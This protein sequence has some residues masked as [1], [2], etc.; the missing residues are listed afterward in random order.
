M[1]RGGAPHYRSRVMKEK[2]K[3]LE[4]IRRAADRPMTVRGLA[5][6]LGIKRADFPGFKRRIDELVEAGALVRVRRTRVA[7]PARPGRDRHE[8]LSL[9]RGRIAVTRGGAGFVGR[10]EGE[11]VRVSPA[12]LGGA[13][14]GD[15][16]AVRLAGR[17]AG[18]PAGV[19]VRVLERGRLRIV[20][21][22]ESG[23]GI[24]R[25]LPDDPRLPRAFEILPGGTG[26]AREGEK[27]VVL[28]EGGETPSAAPRGRVAEVLGDP[29]AP[30]VDLLSV[31]RS[32]GLTAEFPSR[33][34]EEAERAAVKE[35]AEEEARR[36][37]RTGDLVYTIDPV[38]A[39][40]HD[41]AISVERRADG[42]R[43]GV[44]IA[45]VSFYVEEGTALD[46]EAFRRGNSVYLPGLVIPMLPESLSND[47]CSLRPNRRR[48]AHSVFID[49]DKNGLALKWR[50]EDTVIRSR[51][52]LAYEE[53]QGFFDKGAA[54]ARIRRVAKGLEVARELALLLYRRRSEE[55]SLDFDLPEA[56]IVLDERGEVV[57]LGR[58]VRLE[59][60]RLI[61]E[62]M[63]AANRAV[64]R[65]VMGKGQ[66]FLYRVHGRPDKESLEFFSYMMN[67]LGFSFPVSDDARPIRFARFLEKVK[68][69][70][71]ADL[72]HELMLRSMQKA[73]Y[74]RENIGHFGLAFRHYTH[75]TSPIRRYPDLLVHRMLRSLRGRTGYLPSYAKRLVPRIDAA[76]KHC[77]ETERAAEAAERR[78]VRLLQARYMVRHVG[79][80]Y[81]GRITGVAGYGL[82]VRLDDLGVEGLVRAS[83]L[84]GEF[85][86]DERNA[87]LVGR[88]S[89]KTYGLG[90]AI[91]VG[92]AR[93]DPLRGEIDLYLPGGRGPAIPR[94]A[95][96]RASRPKGK[97]SEN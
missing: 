45:D 43:L 7:L 18:R 33:V 21:V 42:Y 49:F 12:D 69:A 91:R 5:R 87:R 58:R 73:V 30:G 19:V 82:F 29:D 24:P 72:V 86:H 89:R 50:F 55:G 26:G 25:V 13:L 16:V 40:D 68:R 41:D 70:P 37:D 67:R 52:K 62:F 36:V 8:G 93:V 31:A 84:E 44:H 17:R 66:P 4:R 1:T 6:A 48:L 20:G 76:G 95:P 65:E 64:A 10:E 85:R 38:D 96:G 83:T 14:D 79:E 57:E 2:E 53:V 63:L 9:V 80:E 92:I 97:C 51:A 11:D 94:R 59:S 90:D 27:V 3:L 32:F 88:R 77:S 81:G 28:V 56:R 61:E 39:K 34:V 71:E 60:H 74:Q 47:V 54:D 23:G 46:R 75:F 15:Q 35:R 78:A 22:F